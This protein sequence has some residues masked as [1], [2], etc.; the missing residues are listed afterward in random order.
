MRICFTSDLHGRLAH[1]DELTNLLLAE[2]PDLLILGGDMHLDGDEADPVGA[3]VAFV[4]REL[5]PRLE[6][7]KERLPDLGILALLGN[8]DFVPTGTAVRELADGDRLV[9]LDHTH[10]W[11]KDGVGFLGM[12]MTPPTPHWVK[13]FERLDVPGDAIPDFGGS[14]W[15]SSAGRL[16]AVE[17]AEHFRNHPTM[18]DE[19][20]SAPALARPWIFVCHAPPY[21][22][23]LDR[24]PNVAAPIGSRA[25][26]QFIE[27][28]QPLCALHGHVHESPDVTGDYKDIVGQ[29]FCVNPG[30]SH[31]RLHA[32]V[33]D[34]LRIAETLRHTVYG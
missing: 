22:T 11:N 9:L 16:R 5:A 24:L 2:Q 4:R 23:R 8:H 20:R 18:V 19:L 30:Q 29:T 28:R 13:D 21:D 32:V 10:C 17:P 31:D 12:A 33:F 27:Q 34:T 15:D 14:V 25:V 3:Q 26:R 6:A 1:Y 7:W